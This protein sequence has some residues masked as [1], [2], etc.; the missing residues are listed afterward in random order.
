VG[1]GGCHDLLDPPGLAY[2]GF[3]AMGGH[4][5]AYESGR[6][7]DG[8]G[9]LDDFE[10]PFAGPTDLM[11]QLMELPEVR[12]CLA[13]QMFR[14][15]ASRWEGSRDA[16]AIQQ[17]SDTLEA[18]DGQLASAFIDAANTDTFRYRLGE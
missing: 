11:A 18:S 8:S 9:S 7:V 2:E 16:C 4:R 1:C 6:P 12:A 17:I 15:T 10:I 3:D 5:E 14:Y 13:R